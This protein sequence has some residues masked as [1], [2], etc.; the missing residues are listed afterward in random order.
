[1]DF[2]PLLFSQHCF[3]FAVVLSLLA[4]EWDLLDSDFEKTVGLERNKS[5][6]TLIIKMDRFVNCLKLTSIVVSSG[7]L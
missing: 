3:F 1:M 5:L 2:G 6:E 7:V 4:E